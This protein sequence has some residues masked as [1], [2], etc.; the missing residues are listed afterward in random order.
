MKP[1]RD[2][3]WEILLIE[4][5]AAD[6]YLT[7]EALKETGI[8]HNLQVAQDGVVAL[9]YLQRKGDNA[10]AVRPDII[11]LDLNMP[12]MSGFELLARIKSDDVLKSIPVIILSSSTAADD[13]AK[14]YALN[15]NCYTRKPVNIDEFIEVINGIQ[16]FWFKTAILPRNPTG[17]TG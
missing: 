8:S 12:R 1:S 6:V 17:K 16:E 15:A 4:D 3:T 14:A 10:D 13:V 5:N 2:F 9:E 11:L 7:R